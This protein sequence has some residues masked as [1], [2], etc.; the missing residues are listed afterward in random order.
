MRRRMQIALGSLYPLGTLIRGTSVSP[1]RVWL[2]GAEGMRHW[3]TTREVFDSLFLFMADVVTISDAAME[4][5]PKGKVI[6]SVDDF[7]DV[8]PK[9]LPAHYSKVMTRSEI[10]QYLASRFSNV[11]RYCGD[12]SFKWYD[13]ISIKNSDF[14]CVTRL[15]VLQTIE[16]A[17]LLYVNNFI[18]H[19]ELV[20]AY[21][22]ANKV[23]GTLSIISTFWKDSLID[24][25]KVVLS[26]IIGFVTGGGPVGLFI[27]AAGA[28]AENIRQSK[29]RTA[30]VFS[31][32]DP[33][34]VVNKQQ[35]DAAATFRFQSAQQAEQDKIAEQNNRLQASSNF[36][37][38]PLMA[39]GAIALLGYAVYQYNNQ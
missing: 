39:F 17:N 34:L 23:I 26:A 19:D 25:G 14:P 7:H 28:A 32:P 5:I 18:S 31:T 16:K 2:I 8:M 35:A 12:V 36:K 24:A 3:I 1:E 30:Q 27:G 13:T 6:N 4:S 10:D 9:V 20:A 21:E 29:I 15:A 33:T 11:K 38:H 22:N 37:V